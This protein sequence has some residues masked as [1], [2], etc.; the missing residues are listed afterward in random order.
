MNEKH[1]TLDSA[2]K[3]TGKREVLQPLREVFGVFF[4][5]MLSCYQGAFTLFEELG[6]LHSFGDRCAM[7]QG[8][9][10][11]LKRDTS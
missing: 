2:R 7:I 11:C 6:G 10:E 5:G 8:S 3:Y 9:T 4:R 1:A